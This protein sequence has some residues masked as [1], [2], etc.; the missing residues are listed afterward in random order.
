MPTGPSIRGA[1]S[2]SQ[3]FALTPRRTHALLEQ[4]LW[5]ER[6]EPG[7]LRGLLAASDPEAVHAALLHLKRRLAR[8]EG[9][10][11]PSSLLEALPVT[12]GACAPETHVLLAEL[13][14]LLP[15]E[16]PLSRLACLTEGK[17]P[18]PLDAEATWLGTEV[19]RE[20]ATLVLHPGGALL[21]RAVQTLSP[22]EAPDPEALVAALCSHPSPDVQRV[23]LRQLGDALGTGLVTLTTALTLAVRALEAS[24]PR[25]ALQATELLAEPWASRPELLPTVRP[26][27]TLLGRSERLATAA[28]RAL[29]RQGE[30]ATLRRVLEDVRQWRSS[31]REAMALLAPFAGQEELR[32]ALL[33]SREDP[34]FFGPTCAALLQTLYRRGVRCEPDDVPLVRELFLASPGTSPEVVAEV[35]S[36]RQREYVDPLWSLPPSDPDFLRHL[37]L[38]RELEG[39]EALS[40]LRSLLVRPDARALWPEVIEALGHQGHETAEED[41]LACFESEPWACINALR[42]VGGARTVAFLRAHP[43]LRDSEAGQDDAVMWRAEALDLLAALDDALSS[44]PSSRA[45]LA[46]LQPVFDD[47]TFAEVSRIALHAWHPLRL[48]AIGQLGLEARQRTLVPLGELLLEA[49]EHVRA[50]AHEAIASVGR[51]LQS[52]GR[53]R[54]QRL[55]IRTSGDETGALL[56]TE[57][58][59]NPLQR[60]DLSDAQLERVLGQLAGRKHPSLARRVRRFLR[61]GSV[62]VQKLALEC[63]AGCGDARA[64]AWLVPFA[65]SE[66]IYRLRQ[67]LTGLGVFKVE[68]AVPLVAAGLDHPNMNIKKAAAEALANMGSGW[69]APVTA[70]LGWLRRHDNPGLRRSLVRALRA[71]CGRGYVATVL[72]ALRE[73]ASPREQ[74]LLCEALSEVLSPEALVALLRRGAPSARVLNDAVRGGVLVLEPEALDAL[75]VLLRRHGLTHWIPA[76]SV[77]PEQARRLRERRLDADLA[78]MDDLLSSGDGAALEAAEADFMKLLSEAA[79]MGLSDTWVAIL[80]RHLD[81]T[82]GLLDSPEP[83][84]RRLACSLLEALSGRLSEPERIGVLADVRRALSIARL[85]PQ[86]ALTLMHRLGAVPSLGEARMASAMPEERVALWGAERLVLAGEVS[87]QELVDAL[88]QSRS[89][90]VRRFFVPF[91]L[92][93]MPPLQ[94]LGAV[95]R[96]PHPDLL[97]TVRK[98]WEEGAAEEE[99]VAGVVHAVE[100]AGLVAAGILVRWLRD[101]G[102][103]AA[104]AALRRLARRPEHGLALTALSALETPVSDEDE[105]LLVELV[106]H[107]HV[108]V[109]RQAA[110]QLWRVRGLPRLQSLLEQLGEERPLRWVPPEAPD[111]RDLEALRAMLG[112]VEAGLEGEVWLESL[113]DLLNRLTPETRQTPAYVTLL[114]D[115]W[116]M[117]RGRSRTMAAGVL[118]S[119]PASRVLPFILPMLREGHTAVLE[120]LTQGTAWGPELMGLFLRARGLDRTHFLELLERVASASPIEGHGLEEVLFG[121]VHEDEDHRASALRVLGGLAS[122]GHREEAFRMGGWLSSLANRGGDAAALHSLLRGLEQQGAEVRIALLARVTAPSLRD[123]VVAALAPLVLDDPSLERALTPE[124]LRDVERRLETLAWEG[125]EPDPKALEVMALR[126]GPHVVERLTRFLSHR[127]SWVRMRAHRLLR[128]LVPRELYLELTRELLKDP[129]AGNVVRAIRTLAFGGHRPAVAEVA[130]LLHDRRNPVARAALD[131]LRVM[132]DAALPLLR[133]ALA[134]ARPDRRATLAQVIM[135]LEQGGSGP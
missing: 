93:A 86:E 39:A 79:T 13:A 75:D 54:P 83:A 69:P 123:E 110:R 128:E 25:V 89:A 5:T 119:L 3:S 9:E 34:L 133:G 95:A 101:V 64:V 122:W 53:A 35:L 97:E 31:R 127:K 2:Y 4:R 134:H 105:T 104:R 131:G 26:L 22:A 10:D 120:V 12:L 67:A 85:E 17:G 30:S 116:R 71:A 20:P 98:E 43:G 47:A 80:R 78:W 28:L 14:R 125:S 7:E 73:A 57:C 8:L 76:T 81:V 38:L 59:L 109:R 60:T 19:L 23:G 56:L 100:S 11:S 1:M 103:E 121:I 84:L 62:Q 58:L 99:W 77:D 68:W 106:S 49:D 24:D 124:M 15:A 42:Q 51:G 129:E 63:L 61:H 118:R 16:I 92:R 45:V 70:L 130:A 21:L 87:G 29:A 72:E 48:Q 44:S 108:E 88:V 65:R 6:L 132:G 112:S 41:L 37:A 113:L 40:L 102:T 27:Q 111:R 126:G 55:F 114:L 66:D 36:L 91:A 46:S 94:V 135:R 32:L 74:G 107:A 50:A 115:V 117:G 52:S 96:G 82:R 90:T 33:V 18:R